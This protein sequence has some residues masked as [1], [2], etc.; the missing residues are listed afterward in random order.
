MKGMMLCG[1]DVGARTSDVAID[2][3]R[4]PVWTG[5][6]VRPR[7]EAIVAVFTIGSDGGRC[8][9]ASCVQA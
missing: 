1:V 5:A 7:R 4:G 3:D 9:R 8:R 2:V 6:F